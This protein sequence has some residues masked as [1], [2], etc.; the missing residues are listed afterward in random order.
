MAKDGNVRIWAWDGSR[1]R[2]I[3]IDTSGH[4][5]V[6]AL[7][8]A[9]PSN[10]DKAISKLIDKSVKYNETINTGSLSA[11]ATESCNITPPSGK[12]WRYITMYLNALAPP[13]A[14]SGTHEFVIWSPGGKFGL[15]RGVSTYTNR[16]RFDLSYWKDA[17]SSKE[18]PDEAN[19]GIALS[20]Q[21]WDNSYPF[22]V[23]YTNGTDVSQTNS[24]TYRL[25][26]LEEYFS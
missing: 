15:L 19:L 21:V 13:G 20:T 24:R 16:L 2:E 5:Q 9:N 18:P 25:T 22:K 23:T 10:L 17:N 1:F 8:V 3:L 14:S 7:S 12:G 26:A 4:P 11:G 6:D